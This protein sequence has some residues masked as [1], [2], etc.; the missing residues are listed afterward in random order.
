MS[1]H[2]QKQSSMTTWSPLYVS[3]HTRKW[4]DYQFLILGLSQFVSPKRA[5]PWGDILSFQDFVSTPPSP[6]LPSR[7]HLLE[8]RR[9]TMRQHGTTL[10]LFQLMSVIRA[11]HLT[12]FGMQPLSRCWYPSSLEEVSFAQFILS[13]M[14]FLSLEKIHR[15]F[16]VVSL[17]LFL[18]RV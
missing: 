8:H 16:V 11:P 10:N 18:S 9:F 12:S 6:R 15:S 3:W 13:N 14:S 7:S 4:Q 2:V 17:S 5:P 1:L